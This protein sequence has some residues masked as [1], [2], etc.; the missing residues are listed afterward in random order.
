MKDSA[1]IAISHL[2]YF[3][4]YFASLFKKLHDLTHMTYHVPCKVNIVYKKKPINNSV[5][6]LIIKLSWNMHQFER[7]YFE[8]TPL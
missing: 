2:V 8:A 3:M 5:K 6:L 1:K 7:K 4:Q